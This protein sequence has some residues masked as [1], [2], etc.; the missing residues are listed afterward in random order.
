MAHAHMSVGAISTKY[1]L[2]ERRHNY[3][4]PK[5]FLEQ[6]HLFE[7]LLKQKTNENGA[8][9]ER[10]QNGIQKLVRC[11]EQVSSFIIDEDHDTRE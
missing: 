3:T 2:N 9:I 11:A 6:L 7:K 5:S 4:T 8:N 10:F 1:R